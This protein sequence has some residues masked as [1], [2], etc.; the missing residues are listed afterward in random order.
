MLSTS[1]F[2][3]SDLRVPVMCLCC[4]KGATLCL[5]MLFGLKAYRLRMKFEPCK[6]N[7]SP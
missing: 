2:Y 7:V 6:V 1:H 4:I 3:Y 5:P